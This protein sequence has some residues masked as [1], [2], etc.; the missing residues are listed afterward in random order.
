MDT[1]LV[2]TWAGR[3]GG[4]EPVL[5]AVTFA[6]DGSYLSTQTLPDYSSSN[7]S[8]E[9]V[10]ELP[11][12]YAERMREETVHGTYT[13]TANR[14]EARLDMPGATEPTVE[15]LIFTIEGDTLTLHDQQHTT[16]TLQRAS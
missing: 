11:T 7:T 8:G 9:A 16:M 5:L 3:T 15:Q 4:E 14:I 12:D 1:S 6:A 2:G 13:I 10:P